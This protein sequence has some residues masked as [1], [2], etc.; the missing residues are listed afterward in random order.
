MRFYGN[1]SAA[2]AGSVCVWWLSVRRTL[3]DAL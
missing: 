1:T 3:A 2:L